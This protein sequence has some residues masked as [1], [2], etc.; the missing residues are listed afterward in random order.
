LKK[1]DYFG[2][3]S[4]LLESLRTMDVVAKTPC[5]CYSISI[6][7]FKAMS[8]DQYKSVLYLN[9][10]KLAFSSSKRLTQISP[11]LIELSFP[12]FQIDNYQKN[13]VVLPSGYLKSSK[14]VIV[15]EG[16]AIDVKDNNYKRVKAKK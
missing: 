12:S 9:L 11:S 8:G 2:E 7:T 1:G 14:I 16:N 10:I 13:E 6:E 15:I 4:I 3:K 5:I